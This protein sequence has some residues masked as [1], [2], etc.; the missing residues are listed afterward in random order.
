MNWLIRWRAARWGWAHR[1][2][3]TTDH[4]LTLLDGLRGRAGPLSE[5]GPEASGNGTQLPQRF[6]SCRTLI[7]AREACVLR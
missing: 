5:M 3:E 1:G 7:L 4:G 6:N 2:K